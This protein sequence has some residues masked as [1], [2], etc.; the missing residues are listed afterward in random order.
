MIFVFSKYIFSFCM[1]EFY[2]PEVDAKLCRPSRSRCYQNIIGL[3]LH[4]F[5]SKGDIYYVGYTKP[6]Q[7]LTHRLLHHHS[8]LICRSN[9]LTW[10]DLIINNLQK[11]CLPCLTRKTTY[12][13]ITLFTSLCWCNTEW[14]IGSNDFNNIANPLYKALMHNRWYA[15][16]GMNPISSQQQT[17]WPFPIYNKES[18]R[19][20]LTVDG[21]IN[22]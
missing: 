15:T 18:S 17:V 16:I 13:F 8:R 2:C 1:F 12:L 7:C 4:F 9:C 22:T 21:Q 14:W 11:L 6:S 3:L 20:S 5:N 19:K 10:W